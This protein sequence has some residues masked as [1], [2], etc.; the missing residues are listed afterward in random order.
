MA[1]LTTNTGIAKTFQSGYAFI[2]NKNNYPIIEP[3]QTRG[4]FE[5]NETLL[6]NSVNTDLS[7]VEIRDDY[8]KI[9][10]KFDLKIGDRIKGRS[11]NVS[12]EITSLID[13]KA[14]FKTDFSNRKEYGWLDDI[15]K[16]K[17]DYQ[18][19]PDNDYYQNLSYTIKSTVEWDKFVPGSS[20][21]IPSIN[22][23]KAVNHVVRVNKFTKRNIISRVTIED[24]KYG[25]RV[26]RKK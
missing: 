16:L 7:V 11:S 4:E 9:D 19:I 12:A 5:L 10:G 26:W 23:V 15:G 13:N 14:K 17:E 8:I 6:V 18:V 1:G 3:I 24:G 25:V 2:I 22:T 21:F 20:V